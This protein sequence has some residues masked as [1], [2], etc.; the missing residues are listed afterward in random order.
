MVV[1][2]GAEGETHETAFAS[3]SIDTCKVLAGHI[4]KCEN[5]AGTVIVNY[6][7]SGESVIEIGPNIVLYTLGKQSTWK[8]CLE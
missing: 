6:V 7:T 3:A 4:N 1:V 5:K 2:Y 8:S